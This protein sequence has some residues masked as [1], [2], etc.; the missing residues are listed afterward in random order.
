MTNGSLK[1][2]MLWLG[3]FLPFVVLAL[4]R[5]PEGPHFDEEDYAHYLLHAEAIADGRAYTDIG[6]ISTPLNPWVGPIAQPPGL[7]LLLA[8]LVALGGVRSPLIPVVLIG[9]TL[10]FLM[11]AATYFRRREPWAVAWAVGLLCGLQP[12]VLHLASQALS[13]LPFCATIWAVILL[14]ESEREAWSWGR[15]LAITIF[16]V[17]AISTRLA[18]IALIPAMAAFATLHFRTQRFRPLVPLLFWIGAFVLTSAMIPTTA[19]IQG[20]VTADSASLSDVVRM[21]V[22][23]YGLGVLEAQLYPIANS[24]VSRLWHVVTL[25]FLALGTLSAIRAYWR[26]FLGAF[27]FAYAC[28]LLLIPLITTRYIY[29][30]L[31]VILFLTLR[32]CVLVLARL[33][34]L[35]PEG[36]AA[37]R[38]A[39]GS[40][41]I[42]IAA[43]VTAWTPVRPSAITTY[44]DVR[45]LYAALKALP[46]APDPRVMVFRARI[47]VLETG[48]PAMALIWGTPETIVRELCAS[49]ITYVVGGD[50]GTH[51]RDTRNLLHTVKAYPDAF[52]EVYRNPSFTVWRFGPAAADQALDGPA[53]AVRVG[54]AY[55]ARSFSHGTI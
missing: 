9:C 55:A 11:L 37:I 39:A 12:A 2:R 48:I 33:R 8:P 29:P 49:R 19:T 5:V 35:W 7:P 45:D 53:C 31:P 22:S 38:T 13:D 20:I 25:T 52:S 21:T 41:V 1:K 46:A 24:D 14:T 16:G 42:A 15:V 30:L 27:A 51:P 54:R 23:A 10:A 28:M 44:R 18:G 40:A 47:L 17:A 6:F 36:R 3:A 26:S 32:G 34:P 43:V 4:L 50:L